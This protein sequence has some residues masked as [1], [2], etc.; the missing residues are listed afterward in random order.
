MQGERK[1]PRVSW[2]RSDAD[3]A[4]KKDIINAMS[5]EELIKFLKKKDE[6]EN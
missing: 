4:E 1:K 6:K 5:Y 2:E 3:V